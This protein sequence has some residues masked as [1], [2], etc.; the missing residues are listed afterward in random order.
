MSEA[1]NSLT[2]FMA[3]FA[4]GTLISRVLGLVRDMVVS[5]LPIASQDIF[6]FAFRFPN[7]LRDMLGEG[8]VNAAFVP[9]FT[10]CRETEGEDAFRRLVRASM[11]AMLIL[12]AAVS[13]LGMLMVPLLPGILQLLEPITGQ[14]VPDDAHLKLTLS[15]MYW[16]MA[17]FFLIGAAV[18]AMGPLFVVKH[19]GTPSWSPVI[20]N[21]ALIALTA[22]FLWRSEYFS[23][24]VW[25]LVAG[26]WLGGIGQAAVMF[27]AMKKHTGVWM[28][29]LELG[30]PGVRHALFLL[31]PVIVGQATGEV[32]KLVDG[33]FAYQLGAVTYLYYS[34]RLVQLPLS[35]FGIAVA[36]SILPAISAAGARDDHDE[37]RDTLRFGLR[38][39]AFLV[40]PALVGLLVL[41]EPIMQLLFVRPSGGFTVEHA[42]HAAEAMAYLVW[43][44]LAFTWVKVAV[45]GFFAVHDTKSPVIVASLSMLLN[46]ALNFA[47]VKPMGFQGRALATA[48][49][50]SAN[51][52]GLY[53]LLCR[54]Y[55]AILSPGLFVSLTKIAIAAASM[56]ATV[57]VLHQTLS[58]WMAAES[59]TAEI[60]R[61]TLP[62]LAGVVVYPALSYLLRIEDVA[63]IQT[64]L[65]RIL[66]GRKRA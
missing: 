42:Q 6:F 18:F 20:L 17:Y 8:A 37:I 21:I 53:G 16:I 1:R 26:V 48:L 31:I 40:M 11:A 29:S 51:F 35:I 39:S 41:G 50:Y 22:V 45:Q 3:I 63:M 23:D 14:S 25:A 5:Q 62:I 30:H 65:K 15:V 57:Y 10:R 49:S 4:G 24:P 56:G 43:G 32:N 61:V 59:H 66:R 2:R 19:Y 60:A 13:L 36:V 28:P 12:F 27:W 54:R 9:L 33:F 38:Q 7:M 34:N 58:G 47:L 52:L 44:L 46:I 55:G 64:L